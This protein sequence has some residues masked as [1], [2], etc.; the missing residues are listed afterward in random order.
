M[1]DPPK[2]GARMVNKEKKEI[3]V[4]L[5]PM[6]GFT[7]KIFR[8][9]CAEGGADFCVTEMVSA[10]ALC[11]GDEKTHS[12]AGRRRGEAPCAV[13][14]FGHEPAQMAKAAEKILDEICPADGVG[15]LPAAIEINM[16]CPVKKI[17]KGGDGSAL[18]RDVKL[19]SEVAGA[20]ADVTGPRGVPLWVKIRAGWDKNS[21]NAA[22]FSAE[23]AA[24]GAKRITVH[25]R[26]RDQMYAPSSDNGVIRRVREA[27][28][29]SVE[30]FGN[31]DV[32]SG[33]DA[34]RM[35]DETGCD[36]ILVGR[37][38]LGD[39]WIFAEIKDFLR[40]G[41]TGSPPAKE[42]RIGAALRL[43]RELCEEKGEEVGVRESR[44]RVGHLIRG[45][46]GSAAARWAVNRAGTEAE[47]ETIL[48]DLL[49]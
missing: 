7:D 37:A 45:I 18:M 12:L 2:N 10:A 13:Q 46:R 4:G 6:A 29:P 35:I 15:T 5:A 49:K 34:A 11:Y 43:L 27:L 33:G 24:S 31:G 39:P 17:V 19:A 42:D 1:A 21:V 25:G 47:F 23:M 38:A 32:T 41:E 20:V 9:M 36:G 8:L 14:I 30:V 3:P 48:T 26:T 40:T 44:A 16:G 22:E 28:D